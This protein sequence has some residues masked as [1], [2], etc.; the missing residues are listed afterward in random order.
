MHEEVRPAHQRLGDASRD[1]ADEKPKRRCKLSKQQQCYALERLAVSLAKPVTSAHLVVMPALKGGACIAVA[2]LS[3]P[4]I[5][6]SHPAFHQSLKYL[7][8]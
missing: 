7:P 1:D 4:A 5:S 8:F 3:R 2:C 6:H